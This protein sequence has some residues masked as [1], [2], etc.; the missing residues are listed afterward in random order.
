MSPFLLYIAR[1]GLYLSL[2]YAFFLL[3][4]RRTSFF[5]LNRVLL[6]AGSYLCL[7]LPLIRL[8]TVASS[9]GAADLAM[10]AAGSETAAATA[11]STISWPGIL[12]GLYIAGAIGTFALF[13]VS[14]W[15]MKRLIRKGE[16]SQRDGYRLVLLE[17]DIPSFSWGRTVVIS[18]KDMEENPAILAHEMMHV[19][20][21]HSLDL[22]LS[23]PV[24]VLFWW[25]PLVWI[26]REE[27]RLLHEY[28]ADEGVIRN[29]IDVAQYQLLLVRKAVGDERFF[30]ASGFQHAK[31][32]SRIAMMLKPSSSEWLRWSYL[33]LIPVMAVM[34]YAC[35]APRDILEPDIELLARGSSTSS[36]IEYPPTFKGGDPREFFL[37]V[38]SQLVYPEEAKQ[39]GIQGRV[40]MQFTVGADGI[41]RNVSVLRGAHELLDAEAVRAVSASPRWEPGRQDGKAV[42]VTYTFPVIFQLQ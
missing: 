41:V 38:N 11:S 31:L 34:M 27:L 4:M 5:R 6:M 39:Q 15:R 18:R 29:G 16:Q 14:A 1:A 26:T 9:A 32:S 35:N 24:H 8:R 21:R 25:N 33:A 36:L 12:L 17:D 7:L 19:E 23:L 30:L 22:L 2:F 40:S 28:E 42:P 20:H 13:G 10:V 3:V 37:W